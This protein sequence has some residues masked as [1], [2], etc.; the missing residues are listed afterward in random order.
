[1]D[2]STT[3][4]RIWALL[5]PALAGHGFELVEVEYG[6]HGRRGLLRL[7][8]DKPGGITLDECAEASRLAGFELDQADL[9]AGQYMLEV[10]SPGFDRPIRKPGDFARFAGE[11]VT[12]RTVTP[13]GGRRKFKGTLLGLTNDLVGLECEGK[14]VEIHV[15]NL[16]KMN[17][18]R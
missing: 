5:E 16:H 10:S 11:R 17:L 3:V 15:E 14:T 13:I 18:D 9:I 12:A 8:F 1:M 7:F 6:Q 2:N 4:R